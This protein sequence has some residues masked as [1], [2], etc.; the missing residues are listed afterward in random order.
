MCQISDYEDE[1]STQNPQNCVKIYNCCERYA[2]ECVKY[3]EPV[4]ECEETE[5]LADPYFMRRL[6]CRKG[7]RFVAGKCKR[8]Y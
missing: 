3:C 4:I 5:N 1:I 6:S 2:D 8:V 7:Y